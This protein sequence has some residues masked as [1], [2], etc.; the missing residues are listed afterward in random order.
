MLFLPYRKQNAISDAYINTECKSLKNSVSYFKI[1]VF[2]CKNFLS[3]NLDIAVIIIVTIQ[4][5]KELK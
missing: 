2:M 5:Y 4:I 1:E 3:L